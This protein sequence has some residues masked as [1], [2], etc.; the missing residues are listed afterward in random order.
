[1]SKQEMNRLRELSQQE[2]LKERQEAKDEL[3]KLKFRLMV[4]RQLP[5]TARL[6]LLRQKIARINT[7]LR[8]RELKGEKVKNA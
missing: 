4:M 2:L 7:L 6:R 5:N 3:F 8:E 1:M